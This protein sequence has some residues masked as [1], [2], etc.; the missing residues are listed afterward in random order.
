[1]AATQNDLTEANAELFEAYRHLN[2]AMSKRDA[3]L[4]RQ[5]GGFSKRFS[6]FPIPDDEEE[7][8]EF[9]KQQEAA[10]WSVGELNFSKDR[11]QWPTLSPRMRKLFAD[12]F[13]FF[14]PADGLISRNVSRFIIESD[15]TFGTA[16]YNVQNYIETVHGLAYGLAVASILSDDAE[17]EDVFG[18]ID[19]I[20][21][22]RQKAIFIDEF[23]HS[24]IPIE[25]R[26]VAAACTE[27]IF[28]VTLFS[29]IFFFRKKGMM[30]GFVFANEQI[31][32]DE[33]MHMYFFCM[34]A[35][36]TLKPEQHAAA[37]ELVRR[38]V[39]TEI[40]SINYMLAEPVESVEADRAMGLTVENLSAYAKQLG[41]KIL[42]NSGVSTIFNNDFD[43]GAR[44]PWLADMGLVPKTNFYEKTVGSYKKNGDY[45][46]KELAGIKDDG[47]LQ[48][49][50]D[51][52][53]MFS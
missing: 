15:T 38:A 32:K 14:V 27:G 10:I 44:L 6:M 40:A 18:G 7:E 52:A 41:D 37:Q 48:A 13:R 11:E 42:A 50:M 34:R 24:E 53:S 30:Q 21:A 16:F 35:R 3:I 8:Y 17:K 23:I 5:A 9:F 43:I 33:T 2:A 47:L 19:K 28:F 20:E 31:S 29:V 49:M 4:L 51:P 12:M 36:K 45:D 25:L 26:Y 1:M 46:W 39:E 22:L